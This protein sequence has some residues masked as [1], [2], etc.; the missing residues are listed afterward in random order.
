[1]TTIHSFKSQMAGGGSR[2]NQFRVTLTFPSWVGGN[3]AEQKIPFMVSAASLPESTLGI[4]SVQFRGRE[5]KWAGDRTFSPWTVNVYNDTDFEIRSALESWS[6]GIV[7]NETNRG[8]TTAPQYQTQALV[9]QLDRN[10]QVLKTY[11]FTD[12]WPIQIGEIGL[13]YG[14][15][16]QIEAFPVTFDYLEWIASDVSGF[17]GTSGPIAV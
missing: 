6:Q 17:V 1:M 7:E 5:I 11:I 14:A 12:F 8:R 4:A 13:D 3:V 16:D 2:P 9:E 10:D 15:N